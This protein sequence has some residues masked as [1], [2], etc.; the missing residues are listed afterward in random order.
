MLSKKNLK[1]IKMEQIVFHFNKLSI[2]DH[3]IKPLDR[4]QSSI[5][6]RDLYI[7]KILNEFFDPHLNAEI[8]NDDDVSIDKYILSKN[9]EC[10]IY[11]CNDKNMQYTFQLISPEKTFLIHLPNKYA[12]DQ[13][14]KY[15]RL[16]NLDPKNHIFDLHYSDTSKFVR[17]LNILY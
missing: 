16:V 14:E 15:I 13:F 9:N 2:S 10:S 7:L 1:I 3:D 11:E 12:L 5:L 6:K 17:L 8:F 4:Y